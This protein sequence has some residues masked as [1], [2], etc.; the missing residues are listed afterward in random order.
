MSLNQLTLRAVGMA[1]LLEMNRIPTVA[2]LAVAAL[3][4]ASRWLRVIRKAIISVARMRFR[5]TMS[6]VL[7]VAFDTEAAAW[8]S[9]LSSCCSG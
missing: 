6:A 4:R 7:S 5:I 8:S 1:R 9:C 2:R 3:R